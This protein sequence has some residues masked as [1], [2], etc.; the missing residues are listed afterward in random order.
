MRNFE[1]DEGRSEFT[2]PI[3]GAVSPVVVGGMK[4]SPSL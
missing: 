3:R 1:T 4:V 2:F